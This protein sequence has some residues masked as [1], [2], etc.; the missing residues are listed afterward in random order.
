MSRRT[1]SPTSD[2]G[3]REREIMD[4]LFG[5]GR[6]TASE[7]QRR[8]PDPPSYSAVRGML[9]YLEKKGKVRH[10]QDGRRYVYEPTM[11]RARAARTALRHVV[12]TFFGGSEE[13]VVNALVENPD[14]LTDEQLDRMQRRIEEAREAT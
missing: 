13:A 1:T 5:L 2:L 3:R 14:S 8:I 7:V 12:D 9:S 4:A 6:A 10:T 11:E